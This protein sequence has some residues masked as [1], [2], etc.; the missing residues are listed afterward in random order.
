MSEII[1]QR[2]SSAGSTESSDDK[3]D[4]HNYFEGSVEESFPE[5]DSR[6]L[7]LQIAGCGGQ[8]DRTHVHQLLIPIP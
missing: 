1:T 3:F 5:V 2:I 6:S 8:L 4:V 7:H